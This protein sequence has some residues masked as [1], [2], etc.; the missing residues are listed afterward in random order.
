MKP[1]YT[2]LSPA[3]RWERINALAIQLYGTERWKADFAR[4]YGLKANTP[5]NWKAKGAPTWPLMALED[6][7]KAKR[8]DE[9]VARLGY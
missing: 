3:E 8:M 2:N 4:K 6:A 7:L 9:I 1:E 5:S